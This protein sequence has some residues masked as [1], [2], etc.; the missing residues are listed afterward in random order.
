[1]KIIKPLTL[2][3]LT[4]SYLI[5][6]ERRFVVS[7]LGFFSLAQP[8]QRFVFE[9]LQWPIVL[10]ALKEQGIAEPL[11]EVLLKPRAEL[12]LTGHAHAPENEPVARMQVTLA[13]AGLEKT[14]DVIGERTWRYAPWLR[15]DAPKPFASMPLG[16]A[17][18]FGGPHH[19]D[20][21]T[22]LGYDR[23]RLA[24]LI[25][26]NSGPMPNL[27]M[28]GRP[29]RRHW[30]RYVPAG[31]GPLAFGGRSRTR[32]A[33]R[34][35]KQWLAHEA[36]GFA[37]SASPEL[38]LRAPADQW[39]DG[40][41]QGGE[42]YRLTGMH[43]ERPVIEGHLPRFMARAFLQRKGAPAIEPLAL[44][45]DTVWFFPELMLGVALYHG[46]TTHVHPLAFDIEAVMVAY[47]HVERPR[48]LAHY[49]EVYARR[50]DL[51]T[52]AAHLFNDSDLAA[53]Y[54]AA[55]VSARTEASAARA[56]KAAARQAELQAARLAEFEATTGAK[57]PAAA[58]RGAKPEA[59][60]VPDS[61]SVDESDFSLEATLA[62]A[63]RMIAAAQAQ[64]DTLRAEY[65]LPAASAVEPDLAARREAAWARASE[66]APDLAASR[67]DATSSATRRASADAGAGAA[68]SANDARQAAQQ[69]AARRARLD[70]TDPDGPLPPEL[71]RWLGRQVEQWHRA[72]V[73]LAGRDLAGVDLSGVDLSGA[74]LRE[75]QLENADLRHA[76]LTGARLDRAVLSGAKLDGADFS[77]ASLRDANLCRSTGAGIRF[78]GADLSLAWALDAQWPG[79]D[80]SDATLE[81]C[82]ASGI[83]LAGASLARVAAANAVLMNASAPGSEWCGARLSATVLM[84]ADLRGAVF[85]H[86]TLTKTVL[87]DAKLAQAAFDGAT[88]AHVVA[89]GAEVDWSGA[90]FAG[91]RAEHCSWQQACLRGSDWR[92][93]ALTA[94]DLGRSDLSHAELSDAIFSG[95]LFTA[96]TLASANLTRANLFRAVCRAADFTGA[97]LA[98]ASLYQADTADAC[99]EGADLRGVVYEAGRRAVA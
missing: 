43:P 68:S 19:P 29:V 85:A 39:L 34:Y 89:G 93:A 3:A 14:L 16:Y 20:N 31:F 76:R 8:V 24:A 61:V 59:L 52:A 98:G 32:Y 21:P 60:P 18:A 72:G 53:D 88:L 36:P 74:D 48:S 67:P 40:Y 33:G 5:G 71:A 22:G 11:D 94:C 56:A 82:L 92:G 81:R 2:G 70:Y 42:P 57:L 77:R 95:C 73:L 90:R 28:P 65:P 84:R 69:R 83:G 45:F 55:T 17:N 78:A 75:V 41:L 26:E 25:G 86:A 1:M 12:L 96:A 50:T 66:P 27:E 51:A 62:G 4:R 7:A 97:T 9:N 15:I 63:R 99:F 35:G 23:N 91:M 37:S 13:A 10:N 49:A 80:L 58:M 6:G 47:E 87:M 64:A 38:F 79:A 44:N 54:D 30:V 46:E